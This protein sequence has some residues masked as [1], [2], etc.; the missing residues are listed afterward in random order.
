MDL[1]VSERIAPVLEQVKTFIQEKISPL[2]REYYEQ[3]AVGDRW[4]LNERQT[5]ILE[6]L[7]K[8]AR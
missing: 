1:G 6:G 4:S 5:E 8:E 3:V 2:E 7:K